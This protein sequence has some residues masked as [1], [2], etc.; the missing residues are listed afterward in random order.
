MVRTTSHFGYKIPGTI[1][2]TT[3]MTNRRWKNWALSCMSKLFQS[4]AGTFRITL[5]IKKEKKSLSQLK[6]AQTDS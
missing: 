5:K 1:T 2:L 6:S 4:L 3:F